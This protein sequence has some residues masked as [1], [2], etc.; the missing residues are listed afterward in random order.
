MNRLAELLTQAG[1]AHK[2]RTALVCGERRLTFAE[3]EALSNRI[4]GGLLALGLN[5]GDRVAILLPNAIEYVA[6]DFALI[7]AGLVRVPVNP[8]LAPP[9]IAFIL[10]D[11]RPTV[12]L[13]HADFAGTV[14]QLRK[15]AERSSS[16]DA[17]KR[18][19]P[20]RCWFRSS[21]VTSWFK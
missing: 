20:G 18:L 8:R 9:E 5:R 4:A 7:K 2:D 19:S 17:S 16:S 1:D 3:T 15:N 10:Q 13:F 12:L 21:S 11:C 14:E 6:T